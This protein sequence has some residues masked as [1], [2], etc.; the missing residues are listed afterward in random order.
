MTEVLQ[1]MICTHDA[2]KLVISALEICERSVAYL[3]N[4][5]RVNSSLK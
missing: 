5:S 4:Q 2:E 1:Q 3:F